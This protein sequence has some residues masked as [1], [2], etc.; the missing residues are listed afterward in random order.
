MGQSSSHGV[1]GR[2]GRTSPDRRFSFD[3]HAEEPADRQAAWSEGN[4]ASHSDGPVVFVIAAPVLCTET[5][6][7]RP[8][9]AAAMA[10]A[11][12]PV[13]AATLAFVAVHA[14]GAARRAA[15]KISLGTGS[16]AMANLLWAAHATG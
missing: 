15:A 16:S 7:V 6:V 5:T 13:R 1:V 8:L 4:R 12:L 3:Q 11:A 2:E 9:R 14:I 10:V